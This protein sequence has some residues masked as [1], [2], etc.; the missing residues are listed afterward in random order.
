MSIGIYYHINPKEDHLAITEKTANIIR[1]RSEEMDILPDLV[2]THFVGEDY[3]HIAP[4]ARDIHGR[5]AVAI[6][7]D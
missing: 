1:K 4:Y 2:M 5:H 6:I 7:L 3:R